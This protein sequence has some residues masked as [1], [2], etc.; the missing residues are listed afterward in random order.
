MTYSW[1]LQ[2]EWKLPNVS[3]GLPAHLAPQAVWRSLVTAQHTV[4]FTL[5]GIALLST[6]VLQGARPNVA[7]WPAALALIPSM[8]LLLLG[9]RMKT[10]LWCLAYLLVS[11]IALH[12][13]ALVLLSQPISINQSDGFSFLAAKVAVIMV[14]GSVLGVGAGVAWAVAGYFVAELA[15]GLAQV[16]AAMPAQFDL[17]TL[18]ALIATV[19]TIPLI[20]FTSGRQRRAQPLLHRAAQD[21]QEAELRARIEVKAAAL[22]HD[23]VLNHLAAIAESPRGELHPNLREQIRSDVHALVGE[24]WL[25]DESETANRKV[26]ADWQHSGLFSAIQE[27]RLLGLDV[28]ATGDLVAV[29]RLDRE[30]SIALGLAVKQCLVNVVKHSGTNHAEVAVY[31][32]GDSVSVMVVDTGRGFTEESTAVDR[33]GLRSSVRKRI[34]MVE[35]Q[36]NVW[37]TPGRGTSVMITVPASEGACTGQDQGEGGAP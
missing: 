30:A 24:E 1:H 18:I 23:T 12:L 14:G 19:L 5:L 35:G 2:P 26:R 28:V 8:T 10:V 32:T 17:P 9:N 34:E 6:L 11:G 29:G 16:D 25:T 33:L 22:M 15:V 21:E 37:S 36:V 3:I 20:S 4:A 13:H 31:G 7:I 27:G